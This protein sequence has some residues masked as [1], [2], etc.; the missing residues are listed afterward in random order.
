[1]TRDGNA[2]FYLFKPS[3]KWAYSGRGYASFHLYDTFT[4]AE[5][6]AQILA[7]NGGEMPGISGT[8]NN[9]HIVVIGDDDLA[10]GWPLHINAV[11]A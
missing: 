3:G 1:M 10:H 7:D 11:Q 6:R 2:T 5:Q 4:H 9:Y 8:G